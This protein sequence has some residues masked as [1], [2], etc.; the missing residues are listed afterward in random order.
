MRNE[1]RIFSDFYAYNYSNF[2]NYYCEGG[3]KLLKKEG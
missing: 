1:K 2:T 3:I